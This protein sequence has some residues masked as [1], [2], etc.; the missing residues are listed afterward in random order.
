MWT[1]MS[2]D[3]RIV[4]APMPGPVNAVPNRDRRLPPSTS[5]VA[6]SARANSSSALLTSSPTTWW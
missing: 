2:P 4:L 3:S 5:W 1:S 6:F